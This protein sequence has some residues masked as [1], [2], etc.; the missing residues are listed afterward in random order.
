M[1]QRRLRT[2]M[3][4]TVVSTALVLAAVG[5][6]GSPDEP[7]SPDTKASAGSE[8]GSD[9]GENTGRYDSD[10]VVTLKDDLSEM[11]P[12]A[13]VN[14]PDHWAEAERRGVMG[15]DYARDSCQKWGAAQAC[16]DVRLEGEAGFGDTTFSLL[17]FGSK[18][19]ATQAYDAMVDDEER[20]GER[21]KAE[22]EP[23]GS[24]SQVFAEPGNPDASAAVI[25][26]G[27]VVSRIDY[28]KDT[29]VP[30]PDIAKVIAFQAEL[31][32]QK[33]EGMPVTAT[34]K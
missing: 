9:N 21:A 4:R 10:K 16:T 7:K 30:D 12:E 34:L 19:S 33:L 24:Q 18:S 17:S 3:T 32:R 11:R 23:V 8:A 28:Y 27:T 20:Q 15:D 25:R 5:A 26:V 14:V 6:C 29:E 13:G 2:G 22:S 31:I 1:A